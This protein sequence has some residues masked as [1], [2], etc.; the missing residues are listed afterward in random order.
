MAAVAQEQGPQEHYEQEHEEE[1][2]EVRNC[3][4]AVMRRFLH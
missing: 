3:V 4:P 1:W 2:Q